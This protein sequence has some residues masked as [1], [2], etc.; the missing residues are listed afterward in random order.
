MSDSDRHVFAKEVDELVRNFELLR[1]YK[2][3][4]SAKFQQA[5]RDLDGMV[6]KIRV[7]NDEDRETLIRLR[8]RFTSLG[9]AMA[10]AR[11]N[12]DRGVLYEINRELHEIPIRFHG[13]AA[14]MV[15]MAADINKISG[16]VIEQ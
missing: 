7:Q 10:R 15:S 6:E 13:I 8:L 16:L 12:D 1:P 2:R 14:E 9:T 5:K 11:A 4:S 3:D